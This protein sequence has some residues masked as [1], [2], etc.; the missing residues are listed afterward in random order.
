MAEKESIT[1]TRDVNIITIPDGHIGK[2]NAG[3]IVT[4]HQALGDNFTVLTPYGHL[5]RIAGNDAD[6]LGK[7]AHHS[8]ALVNENTVQAVRKTVGR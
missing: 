3:E 5:V 6:A 4:L 7:E 1:L 2:L 8:A